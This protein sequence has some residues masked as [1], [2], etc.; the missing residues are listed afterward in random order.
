MLPQAANENGDA[1]NVKQLWLRRV[2]RKPTTHNN[3]SARLL[4]ANDLGDG[5]IELYDELREGWPRVQIHGASREVM[6]ML[7]LPYMQA[8]AMM[9]S[10]YLL[11]ENKANLCQFTLDDR[12]WKSLV[13][14]YDAA[15][16]PYNRQ[17]V[18]LAAADHFVKAA[19]DAGFTLES[20]EAESMFRSC[21]TQ[22]AP[23]RV[24]RA[25]VAMGR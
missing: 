6:A 5:H 12:T 23:K 21:A 15:Q 8:D 9:H 25:Q 11:D 14:S 1:T 19:S 7:V 18:L 2:G 17:S 13:I 16:G 20:R 3:V 24:Q 22:L 4:P 10:F